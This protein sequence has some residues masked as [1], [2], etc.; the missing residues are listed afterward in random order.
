MCD[1]AIK[2]RSNL[3]PNAG[4]ARKALILRVFFTEDHRF[5]SGQR[6]AILSDLRI[7]RMTVKGE[8]EES[9]QDI[10]RQGILDRDEDAFRRGRSSPN[11]VSDLQEGH[12]KREYR[13]HWQCT[14]PCR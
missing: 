1:S 5:T 13:N 9:R 3:L 12:G 4:R 6:E 10:A 2:R 11:L 14:R 7:G 8:L